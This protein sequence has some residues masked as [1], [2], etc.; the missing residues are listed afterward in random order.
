MKIRLRGGGYNLILYTK[1]NKI[2]AE[3][4]SKYGQ[5]LKTF[6]YRK[7]HVSGFINIWRRIPR[8]E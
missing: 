6:K 2:K 7:F 8:I 3:I 1:I 5:L 4:L